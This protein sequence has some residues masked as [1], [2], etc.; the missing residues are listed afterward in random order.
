MLRLRR[1]LVLLLVRLQPHGLLW[2]IKVGPTRPA[3][4]RPNK[5]AG[6]ARAS[7]AS[8]AA[9]PT[10]T[11]TEQVKP[12]EISSTIEHGRTVVRYMWYLGHGTQ[13]W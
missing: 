7:P 12:D 10:T 2:D 6:R 9:G 3:T 5:F 13:G 4:A 8:I 11:A 1:R